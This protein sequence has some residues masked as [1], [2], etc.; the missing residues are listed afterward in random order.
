MEDV[1][2]EGAATGGSSDIAAGGKMDDDSD[3]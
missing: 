2:N 1:R 3:R